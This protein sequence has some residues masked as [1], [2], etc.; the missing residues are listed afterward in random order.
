MGKGARDTWRWGSRGVGRRPRE[1]VR[2]GRPGG[3]RG[4]SLQPRGPG[5]RRNPAAPP[6]APP[7]AAAAPGR[8][9]LLAELSRREPEP[10]LPAR[11][12]RTLPSFLLVSPGRGLPFQDWRVAGEKAAVLCF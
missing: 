8:R 1:Q 12:G 9:L 5:G 10:R 2:G 11:F 4:A 7:A 6:R 3:H